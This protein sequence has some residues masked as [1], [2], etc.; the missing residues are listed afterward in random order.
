V[1][2]RD[3]LAIVPGGPR[4]E[5]WIGSGLNE[6]WRGTDDQLCFILEVDG[7]DGERSKLR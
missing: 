1:F 6:D 3:S 2:S 5:D 7:S 4:D